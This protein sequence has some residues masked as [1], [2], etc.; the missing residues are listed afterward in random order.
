[1]TNSIRLRL[2]IMMFL[3]YAIWGAWAPVIYT[4]LNAL[5]F[6]GDQSSWIF[7]ALWLACIIS[8]FIGG[9]IVDRWF[10]TQWFLA[11][12]HFVGGVLLL[13]TAGAAHFG[14]MML[15]MSAYSLLYAPTLALTNSLAFHHLKNIDKEFPLI[16]AFG[17]F[18]WIAAGW[19]L[20]G[21]R[22]WDTLAINYEQ[23]SDALYLAAAMS[24]IMGIFCMTLPHT[25]PKKEAK[26]P[27]A[28]LEALKLFKNKQFAIFIIISFV[29]TT[30][31]Q[32]YYL[33]TSQFLEDIGV[34]H[35][36]V[37]L[38]MTVAQIAEMLIMALALSY[39]L[40]RLG[41]RKCLAIGVIAWP[42]RYLVFALQEPVWLVVAS[43]A[44]HGVGYTFFFVV[45][46]IYVDEVA[47]I[48]IRASAQSLLTLIT[49]GIG[50]F[51][52]TKFTGY[53]L[54]YFKVGQVTEW[55]KVFLVPC[56]LTILCA[57]AF[58][59]FFKYEP[60]RAQGES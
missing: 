14:S 26:N 7:G 12:V 23:G 48:D 31:L 44:L 5:G 56:I 52:G 20:S 41:I 17:T 35:S 24:L 9:Q 25:P 59:L 40:P 51:L 33:P 58:L 57:V 47:P 16:R 39:F 54:D 6:S 55:T 42:I 27:W 46:Q 1:M 32:F 11:A 60:Q 53:I 49:L 36:N 10:P 15:L 50:N 29:V 37:P 45:S 38:V 13:I 22:N 18:G 3:Q 8:P 43:L 4:H 19:L 21:W 30:E 34:A 28:F 2:I